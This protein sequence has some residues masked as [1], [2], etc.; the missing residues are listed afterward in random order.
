MLH[1]GWYTCIHFQTAVHI[2]HHWA[3]VSE[4]PQKLNERNYWRPILSH[5]YKSKVF[6]FQLLLSI[7]LFP[8]Y[9]IELSLG[10]WKKKR[11]SDH[12]LRFFLKDVKF[13]NFQ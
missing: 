13:N 11:N 8:L 4:L 6:I 10:F 1:L 12:Y 5:N 9:F 3:D 7:S 2:V